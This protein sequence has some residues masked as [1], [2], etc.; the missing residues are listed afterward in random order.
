MR[1]ICQAIEEASGKGTEFR[2][3]S[4]ISG[5]CINKALRLETTSG[6]YFVKKNHPSFLAAFEA[7][8]IALAQI[9]ETQTIRVPL[10]ICYGSNEDDSY[11]VLEY[12]GMSS[13][14]PN[15]QAEA[16]QRLAAMHRN[17]GEAF[18][19]NKDNTIGATRQ[20]NPYSNS[21]I[22]F[23]RDHRLQFQFELAAQGGQ[24]FHNA[25]ILLERI[26]D[27]FEGYQPEP[28]ILHGDL[29]GGNIGY[30][31]EGEP[32]IF[33]PAT[34]YGDRETDL[35][36]T[37][38]FGGFGPDFYNAYESTWPRHSGNEIRKTLY[39]LYHYLNHHN[40]FGGG[41]A[42]TAQSMINQLISWG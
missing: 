19:W 38:M 10:P 27:F 29:W 35:A 5:G 16:G 36:F 42:N 24:T 25:E 20:P 22:E 26:G 2:S 41:Y 13:P 17:C 12:I 28:S 1:A 21:W 11:L 23:Y 3:A 40:L 37:E 32:V 6:T 30:T 7:E 18:G 15:S 9:A 34:Y 14:R 4:P 8:S 39:N 31:Q 33:D